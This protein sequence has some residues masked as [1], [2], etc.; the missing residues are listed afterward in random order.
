M[1]YTDG[2]TDAGNARGKD[3]GRAQ[4]LEWA[5]QCPVESPEV[6]G[7]ELLKRVGEFRG[8]QHNDD[9]TLVVLRRQEEATLSAMV[10]VAW[11]NTFGRLLR[12]GSFRLLQASRPI[13]KENERLLSLT[14]LGD[15]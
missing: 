1:L 4:L 2:I 6:L 12:S 14:G 7:E 10:K 13:R 8:S 11:S 3:L 9:E 15:D 5:R